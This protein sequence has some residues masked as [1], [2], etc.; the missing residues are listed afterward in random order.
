M[1][2]NPQAFPRPVSE[3]PNGDI[4]YAELGMTLRDYFAG[5]AMAGLIASHAHPQSFGYPDPEEVANWCGR[6]ADAMLAEREK[7]APHA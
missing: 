3:S 4:E 7:G 2:E 1:P 5:K 6:Y